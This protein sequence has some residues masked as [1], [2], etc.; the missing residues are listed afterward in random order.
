MIRLD[1]L[2][3]TSPERF[4]LLF[5]DG[6]ELKATLNL[7]T[8]RFLRAGMEVNGEEYAALKE[9]CACSLCQAHALRLIG[10]QALSRKGLLD[11]L[12]QKGEDPE[13]ARRAVDYLAELGLLNDEDFAGIVVRHYAGKGYGP[14]RIRAE[15][16]RHGVPKKL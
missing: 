14:K 7:V 16:Y 3:Q 10:S 12:V 11:K 15:L 9:A 8:D 1:E 6:S 13:N 5:S 2:K 4:T